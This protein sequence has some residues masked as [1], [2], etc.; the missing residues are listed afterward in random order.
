MSHDECSVCYEKRYLFLDLSSFHHLCSTIILRFCN[1]MRKKY[2]NIGSNKRKQP[3]KTNLVLRVTFT[4][5]IILSFSSHIS[6][7][8][9]YS[10]SNKTFCFHSYFPGKLKSLLLF[11]QTHRKSSTHVF[12]RFKF[13]RPSYNVI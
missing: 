9:V 8:Q 12:S 6:S 1:I 11:I 3:N 5:T 2:Q 4:Q 10:I 7:K 13:H